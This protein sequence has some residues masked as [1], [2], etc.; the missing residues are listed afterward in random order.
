MYNKDGDS[1]RYNYEGEKFLNRI[2][3]DLYKSSEVEHVLDK[4]DT[5]EE[6]IRKYLERLKR[7]EEKAKISKYNGYELLKEMY[8]NKYIIKKENIK[9]EYFNHQ[10]EMALERGY[11]H[12]TITDE[13]KE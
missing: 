13:M 4:K 8:Y 9:E 5:K 7:V 6:A 10:K 12:I 1:M 2:Y 3:K 11:G